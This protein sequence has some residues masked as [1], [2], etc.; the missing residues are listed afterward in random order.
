MEMRLQRFEIVSDFL[1]LCYPPNIY[2]IYTLF[3]DDYY[4]NNDD[5]K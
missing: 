3:D 2:W 5:D 4:G 1:Y